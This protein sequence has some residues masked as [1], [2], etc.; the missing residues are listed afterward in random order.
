MAIRSFRNQATE[1]INYGRDSKAGRRV[2]PTVLH[3]KARIKLARLHAAESLGDLATLP[4]NRLETL[5]GD[6]RGQYSIRINDKYRVCVIW[7]GDA[8]ENVEIA[9]YH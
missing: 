2:L 9:D 4:V 3:A 8:A 1:D 7:R 6:R 5:K